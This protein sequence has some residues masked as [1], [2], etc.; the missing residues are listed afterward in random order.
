[1]GYGN[2]YTFWAVATNTGVISTNTNATP[3]DLENSEPFMQSLNGH[4]P[5]VNIIAV[6]N[7]Y[8]IG[9]TIENYEDYIIIY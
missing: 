6:S 9:D 2:G 3:E 1:M 7:Q 8:T 5:N 4:F